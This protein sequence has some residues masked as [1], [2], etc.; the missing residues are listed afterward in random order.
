M[1]PSYQVQG[2]AHALTPIRRQGAHHLLDVDGVRMHLELHW[3]GRHEALLTLGGKSRKIY[4]AQDGHTLFIHLDGRTWRIEAIDAFGRAA[5]DDEAT[6]GR[7]Q[8]PMPGVMLQVHVAVGDEVAETDVLALLESMKMQ[9]EVK[10][11]R[12]GVVTAVHVAVGESFERGAALIV[13]GPAPSAAS[14]TGDARHD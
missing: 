12:A 6:G 5:D 7:I 13:I 8:A 11:P 14:Q 1:P 10:A 3:T 9:T 4:A 2:E